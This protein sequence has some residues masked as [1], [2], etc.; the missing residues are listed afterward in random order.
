MLNILKQFYIF[1][2]IY[3]VY[4]MGTPGMPTCQ[5]KRAIPLDTPLVPS[6]KYHTPISKDS[7]WD[8]KYNTARKILP[9]QCTISYLYI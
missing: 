5:G 9:S 6:P 4:M 2:Y 7:A 1:M 8:V 3:I